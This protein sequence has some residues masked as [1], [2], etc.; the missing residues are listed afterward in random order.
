[1][2][3]VKQI[4]EWPLGERG[5]GW[6]WYITTVKKGKWVTEETWAQRAIVSDGKNEML[7]SFLGKK[8]FT[9]S[10][11]NSPIRIRVCER[12]EVDVNNKPTPII[13]VEEWELPQMTAD[14]YEKENSDLN[15]EWKKDQE[16]RIRG[17]C[18]HGIV[19]AMIQAGWFSEEKLTP[20][21]K[22]PTK[23]S[24]NKLVDYIMT[25]E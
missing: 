20:C 24:I 16:K 11:S 19:C 25:G 1:M 10:S 22:E 5:G 3:T 6:T 17:M 9:F 2:T 13:V 14:E 21:L 23:R 4:L 7:A 15:V 18:R 12:A 8:K